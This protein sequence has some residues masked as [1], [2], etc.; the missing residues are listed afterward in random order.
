MNRIV[1]TGCTNGSRSNVPAVWVPAG[2]GYE[3]TYLG[4]LGVK[5]EGG[6]AE[7]I[8]PRG[9]TIAGNGPS[10]SSGSTRVGA[11]WEVFAP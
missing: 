4:G 6:V 2:S 1:G 7:T 3:I 10:T 8:S 11:I 5:A 9:T